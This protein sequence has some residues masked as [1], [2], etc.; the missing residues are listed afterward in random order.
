MNNDFKRKEFYKQLN[1]FL[2]SLDKDYLKNYDISYKWN[3]PKDENYNYD[4][5]YKW[6]TSNDKI[7]DSIITKVIFIVNGTFDFE[8]ENTYEMTFIYDRE[9][10]CYINYGDMSIPIDIN[11]EKEITNFFIEMFLFNKI[12][13]KEEDKK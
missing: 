9:L 3:I 1:N 8:K 12:E 7:Y 4:I 11:D 10:L 2:V 6:D 13:F 5:S